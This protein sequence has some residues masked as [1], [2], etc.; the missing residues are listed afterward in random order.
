[1]ELNQLDVLISQIYFWNE[2]LHV[3]DNSFVHHL[4][5]KL[6]ANLYDKYHFCVY[7]EKLLMMDRGTV[8]NMQSF[9]PK[10]NLRN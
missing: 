8:R 3:S 6:S 1:M 9:I 7:S 5:S 10:I 2:T 4:A